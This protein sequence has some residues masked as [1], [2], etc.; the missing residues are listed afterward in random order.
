MSSKQKE[1]SLVTR[2]SLPSKQKESSLVNKWKALYD[3]PKICGKPSYQIGERLVNIRK[4][5]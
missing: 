2:E 1:S 4:A 5:Q 3:Q